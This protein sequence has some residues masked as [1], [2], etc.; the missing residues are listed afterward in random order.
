LTS[1]IDFTLLIPLLLISVRIEPYLELH[2][3]DQQTQPSSMDIGNETWSPLY[4]FMRNMNAFGY[5]W[6][7]SLGHFYSPRKYLVIVRKFDRELTRWPTQNSVESFDGQAESV[8]I[9]IKE[10]M[11]RVETVVLAVIS[12][13]ILAELEV[14]SLSGNKFKEPV[15]RPFNDPGNE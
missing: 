2:I 8:Y 5:G 15:T 9:L 14:K 10:H 12:P 1:Q 13:A 3:L 7:Q 6:F 4:G 11:M